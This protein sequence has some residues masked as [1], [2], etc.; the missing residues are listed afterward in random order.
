MLLYAK[1]IKW[2]DAFE[3][4]LS[5]KLA[6]ECFA[7][8][9]LQEKFRFVRDTLVIPFKIDADDD[10]YYAEESNSAAKNVL[11]KEE[12][13]KLKSVIKTRL[14]KAP[15]TAAFLFQE[16]AERRNTYRGLA[17]EDYQ[18]NDEAEREMCIRTCTQNLT[19]FDIHTYLK[20]TKGQLPQFL[21]NYY[22]FLSG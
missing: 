12:K 19:D 22:D 11:N 1:Q 5:S 7:Q 15:Y 8:R 3:I 16:F 18:E 17:E 13:M 10:D 4:L 9:T 21:G 6:R 20:E 2:F 14:C